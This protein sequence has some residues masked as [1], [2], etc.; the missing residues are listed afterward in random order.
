M[1][2][3]KQ[4]FEKQISAVVQQSAQLAEGLASDGLLTASG[5]VLSAVQTIKA[6]YTQLQ[7]ATAPADKPAEGQDAGAGISGNPPPEGQRPR[8][9]RKGK[10]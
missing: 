6:L 5:V 2:I 10:R 1:L 7:V 9:P 3:S 4:E 8:R